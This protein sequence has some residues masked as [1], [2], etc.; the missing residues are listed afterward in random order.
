[1]AESVLLKL[2]KQGIVA[3]PIHDSF[4]VE[5]HHQGALQTAM[6]EVFQKAKSVI[7]N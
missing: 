2:R 3:L 6:D 4:I 7:N 5:Q 1:M